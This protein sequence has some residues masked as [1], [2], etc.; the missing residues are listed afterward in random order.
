MHTCD[1][2]RIFTKL[3]SFQ[4][5]RTLCEMIRFSRTD[6]ADETTLPSQQEMWN[7]LK[8]VLK[9]YEKL[10]K[11]VDELTKMTNKEK[12]QISIIDWLN[13]NKQF[14]LDYKKWMGLI[15]F[16]QD[17]LE[18]VFSRGFIEGITDVILNNLNDCDTNVICGFKQKNNKLFLKEENVWRELNNEDMKNIINYFQSGIQKEFGK[19]NKKNAKRLEDYSKNEEWLKNIKKVTGS[20]ISTTDKVNKIKVKLFNKLKLNLKNVIEMEFS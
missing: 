3:K 14:D 20:L 12:K 6:L 9:K 7:V 13:Q 8:I 10:E 1:C 15:E 5:H 16:T 11:K 19:Y 2:G 18:N 4:E 17:D